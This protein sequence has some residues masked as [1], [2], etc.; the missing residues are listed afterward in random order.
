MYIDPI[1][2]RSGLPEEFFTVTKKMWE[3]QF[4]K[5]VQIILFV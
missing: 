4:S 5:F 1:I 3:A 2:Q